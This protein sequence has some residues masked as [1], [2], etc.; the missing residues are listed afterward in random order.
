MHIK[1][2]KTFSSTFSRL[3][4]NTG[5]CDSFLENA[6]WKMNNFPENVN[7]KTNRALK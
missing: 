4:P 3:L 6:F 7:A 1:Y 2:Q 5:K